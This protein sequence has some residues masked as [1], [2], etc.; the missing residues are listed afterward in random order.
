MDFII[1]LRL[2]TSKKN[3]IGIIMDRLTKYAHFIP[4]HDTW[5]VETLAQ[6][7]VKEIVQLYDILKDPVSDRDQRFQAQFWQALQEAFG[8][9]LNF[10]NSYHP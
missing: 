2:S 8:T 1:G 5:G 10:S 4:I 6:L 7:Y 9:K 3:A